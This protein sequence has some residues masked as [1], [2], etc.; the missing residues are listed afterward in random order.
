MLLK[1]LELWYKFNV[2]YIDAKTSV[3]IIICSLLVSTSKG[4]SIGSE[5]ILILLGQGRISSVCGKF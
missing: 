3:F 1:D 4:N 2:V 5:K